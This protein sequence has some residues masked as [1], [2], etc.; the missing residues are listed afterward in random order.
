M[1]MEI[2]AGRKAPPNSFGGALGDSADRPSGLRFCRAAV[3]FDRRAVRLFFGGT[4]GDGARHCRR[5]FLEKGNGGRGFFRRRGRR[6]VGD[7][8]GADED[9]PLGLASGIWGLAVST[10][11]FVVVSLV[12]EA[13]EAKAERFVG[14]IRR[15]IREKGAFEEGRGPPYEGTVSAPSPVL[16]ARM[17]AARAKSGRTQLSWGARRERNPWLRTRRR[18]PVRSHFFC[19]FFG[20]WAAPAFPSHEY[21]RD[22]P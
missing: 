12:T 6:T 5:V 15:W 11:L 18:S 17:G 13:P 21:R 20:D 22:M 2:S 3:G 19:G 16:A 14:D 10:L 8:S 4:V 9:K 7:F 1:S